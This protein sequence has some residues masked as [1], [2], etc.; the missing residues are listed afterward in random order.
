MAA[1]GSPA[2]QSR[3]CRGLALHQGYRHRTNQEE[4]QGR[5]QHQQGRDWNSSDFDIQRITGED[6]KNRT[7]G[8][9]LKGRGTGTLPERLFQLG[10]ELVGA[11]RERIKWT[12]IDARYIKGITPTQ[13]KERA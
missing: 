6:I 12:R 13:A 10:R 2:T 11:R 9:H 1:R 5:D 7:L 3:D 8:A 4:D